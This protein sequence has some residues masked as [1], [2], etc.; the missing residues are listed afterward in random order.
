[1]S[2]LA[3]K[4]A[5]NQMCLA[6]YQYAKLVFHEAGKVDFCHPLRSPPAGDILDLRDPD[7]WRNSH[8]NPLSQGGSNWLYIVFHV[9]DLIPCKSKSPL[10][11]SLF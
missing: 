10:S 7:K 6:W 3:I 2:R 5:T 9:N 11:W 1:M 8:H 4:L